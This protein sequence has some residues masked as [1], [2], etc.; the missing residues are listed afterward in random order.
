[1]DQVR[2]ELADVHHLCGTGVFEDCAGDGRNR[3]FEE[4]GRAVHRIHILMEHAPHVTALAAEDPF[5][6][7]TFGFFVHLGVEALHHLVR[8]EEPEVAAFRSVGADG[9]VEA[10]LAKEHQVTEQGVVVRRAEVVGRRHNEQHFG[11]FAIDGN[12]EVES[13]DFRSLFRRKIDTVFEPVRLDAEMIADAEAVGRG[14]KHP[15]DVAADEVQQLAAHHGDFGGV[16]SIRAEDGAAAALGALVEV[17]EPL[18]DHILGEFAAAGK[19]AENAPGQREVAAVDGAHQ[20]RARHR[21]VLGIGR[22]EIEVAFVGA[23]AA[24]HADVHEEAE[25]AIFLEPLLH[26]VE[27]DVLP[28]GRKFPVA[29]ERLPGARIGKAESRSDSWARHCSRSSPCGTRRAGRAS[30]HA[31][32]LAQFVRACLSSSIPFSISSGIPAACI[33]S[34]NSSSHSA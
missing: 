32:A 25:G 31:A 22:A 33:L 21:H 19:L 3:H 23:G 1:M 27:D 24:A 18:L 26:A 28:V 15:V 12:F 10:D 20:L 30:R 4:I 5:D 9:V 16:D 8:G 7:E 13:G 14:L 34:R 2:G 17:V 11:A 29:V 6:A